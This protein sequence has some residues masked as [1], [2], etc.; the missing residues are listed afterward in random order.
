MRPVN[1]S[2]HPSSRV[3][4]TDT[5]RPC[6]R[7]VVL[8]MATVLATCVRYGEAHAQVVGAGLSLGWQD[9]RTAPGAG[10][11]NQNFGCTVTI[12]DLPLIPALKLTTAIDSVIACELVIDVGLATSTLPPWWHMEPG[13]C[14]ATPSA[15]SASL[16]TA[17]SCPDAWQGQATALATSWLTS[18]PGSTSDRGRLTVAVAALPG[19]LAR[20]ERDIPLALCRIALRSDNSLTC[21]GCSI[22]GCLVFNSL[23]IRRL[24]GSLWEEA[25]IATPEV[26]GAT[27]VRWQGGLGADCQALPTR[28]STWGAVKA[29]YR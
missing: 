1:P 10:G 26:A 17:V 6:G 9:C 29:L 8:V 7:L 23:L 5:A 19:V 3:L 20:L 13:G 27:W 4:G 12:N 28:R 18:F 21:S 11:D 2:R 25:T 15:W 22:P 16:A 14:R 24:P